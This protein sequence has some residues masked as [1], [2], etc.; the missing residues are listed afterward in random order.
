MTGRA[1]GLGAMG[2]ELLAEGEIACD[3]VVVVGQFIYWADNGFI[4]R[5]TPPKAL[6]TPYDPDN[7]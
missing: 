6:G 5:A 7:A 4:G 3:G 2:F 1:L